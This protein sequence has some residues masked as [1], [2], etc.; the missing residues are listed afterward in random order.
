MSETSSVTRSPQAYIS[1]N[2]ARSRMPSGVS[3]R[4]AVSSRASTSSMLSVSGRERPMRG[5]LIFSVGSRLTMLSST[6][7]PNR[8]LLDAT[9]RAR[10]VSEYSKACRC[11]RYWDIMSSST[12]CQPSPFPLRWLVCKYSMSWHRSLRYAAKVFGETP[13]STA[14]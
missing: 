12:T 3:C 10:V 5:E 6:R 13:R 7:K 1:S 4:D 11:S 9:L 14:I 2:I 8:D